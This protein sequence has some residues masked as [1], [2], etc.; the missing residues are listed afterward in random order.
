MT[1]SPDQSLFTAA[2]EVE[3][4][5]GKEYVKELDYAVNMDFADGLYQSCKNV[6]NPTTG[7]KAKFKIV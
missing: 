5:N 2:A 7:S 4:E 1:C 3:S 6:S